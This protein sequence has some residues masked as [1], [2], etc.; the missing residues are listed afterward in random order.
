MK[1]KEIFSEIP[2]EETIEQEMNFQEEN[3]H[4]KIVYE[5]SEAS[6]ATISHEESNGELKLDEEEIESA[7]K[8]SGM[9]MEGIAPEEELEREEL[10]Q[11]FKNE[12]SF[13]TLLQ[14]WKRK[15]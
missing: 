4:E 7:L 14:N 15:C 6:P 8:G 9:T 12:E 11:V 5:S 1:V 3:P 13:L 2:Q 10:Q